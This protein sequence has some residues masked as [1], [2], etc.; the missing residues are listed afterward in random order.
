[1]ARALT[2]SKENSPM[3]DNTEWDSPKEWVFPSRIIQVVGGSIGA[4]LG[5][6]MI[7]EAVRYRDTNPIDQIYGALNYGLGIN[8]VL[9]G[10]YIATKAAED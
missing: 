9:V 5:V 4:L 7:I 2:R 3:R 8:S 10:G 6:L 1:M